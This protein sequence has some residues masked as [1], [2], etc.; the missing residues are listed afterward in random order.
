VAHDNLAS[1]IFS[2]HVTVILSFPYF[3]FEI[4][5]NPLA[6]NSSEP[7]DATYWKYG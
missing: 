7:S 1:C 5:L 3:F 6:C 4:G 2:S